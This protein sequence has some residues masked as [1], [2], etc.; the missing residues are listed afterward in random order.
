MEPL[1]ELLRDTRTHFRFVSHHIGSDEPKFSRWFEYRGNRTAPTQ[2]YWELFGN[3]HVLA[4]EVEWAGID[5]S[6]RRTPHID[7]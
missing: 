6:K 4:I 5:P 2:L 3:S 7:R 1:D